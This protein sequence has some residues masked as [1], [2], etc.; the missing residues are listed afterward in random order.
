MDTNLGPGK[1][2]PLFLPDNSLKWQECQCPLVCRKQQRA[3]ID[4]QRAFDK[5][6][7]DYGVAGAGSAGAGAGAAGAGSFFGAGAGAFFGAG[8]GA[9]STGGFSAGAGAAPPGAPCA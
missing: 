1:W 5:P 7:I 8:A 6:S 4:D 3:L 9:F 2:L